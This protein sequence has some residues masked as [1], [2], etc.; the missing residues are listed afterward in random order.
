MACSD[1][2]P[3][4]DRYNPGLGTPECF[5]QGLD[6]TLFYLPFLKEASLAVTKKD[7]TI[8]L[9]SLEKE[10]P[11]APAA[12]EPAFTE[13]P[14]QP[15]LIDDQP[16]EQDTSENNTVRRETHRRPIAPGDALLPESK[17]RI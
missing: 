10:A 17:I 4:T 5:F 12:P 6:R 2:T 1:Y 11:A 14:V 15:T 13:A 16:G 8:L 3:I 7:L 9:T